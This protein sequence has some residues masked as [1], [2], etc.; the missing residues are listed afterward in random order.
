M[1]IV[2]DI[3]NALGGLLLVILAIEIL[4]NLWKEVSRRVRYGTQ[5]KADYRALADAYEGAD[6]VRQYYVDFWR[7][8]IDWAPHVGGRMRPFQAPGITIDEGGLRRTWA[9]EGK[10]GSASAKRVYAFGGSTMLGAGVRDEETVPSL[11]AQRLADAGH[12]VELVNYGQPAYTAIQSF[13]TFSEEI[14]RGNVPH[15]ALFL[16]GQNEA[17]TAEQSGRAG[18][19]FNADS[20]AEELNLLQPWRRDDLIRHALHA[21][22]PRIMRRYQTLEEAI[23]PASRDQPVLTA[24]NIG[25]LSR[26][27][28][29]R[30][31]DNLRHIRAVA[32]DNGVQ[33]LF[34][35]QPILF[36]KK[37]LTDHEARYQHDGAPVPE[38]RAPLFRAVYGALTSDPD[39]RSM[40]GAVDISGLF[41]DT[42]EPR[43][44]D[45]FHLAEKGNA[46][47]AEAM[48][49][50][51]VAVLEKS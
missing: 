45:P 41:D 7:L 40:P 18:T 14:A 13:I 27:V 37:H 30:Y 46:A 6:W 9:P 36:T 15:V 19:V 49:P 34:F 25:P 38:L 5:R 20:R 2:Q 11:L 28:A 44:I 33:T 42:P 26:E 32:E 3:W 12:D 43:F 35:W 8:R 21:V 22:L 50:H 1:V 47:V 39:F 24:E 10:R 16:D 4:P 23:K 48:L 51:V 17:I 29:R 31:L